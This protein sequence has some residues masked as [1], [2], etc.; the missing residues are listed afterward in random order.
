[1]N[2]VRLQAK[3]FYMLIVVKMLSTEII[4]DKIKWN[5]NFFLTFFRCNFRLFSSSIIRFLKYW[6]AVKIHKYHCNLCKIK[7]SF[8]LWTLVKCHTAHVTKFLSVCR[9]L[10]KTKIRFVYILHITPNFASISADSQFLS[11]V[12]T[13]S[14][15]ILSKW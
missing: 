12:L 13:Q 6:S 1:M 4:E 10:T 11:A 9:L 2:I 3:S 14:V 7:I 15:R 5:Q 8:R